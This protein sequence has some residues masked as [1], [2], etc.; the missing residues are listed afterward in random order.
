MIKRTERKRRATA[1]TLSSNITG[2]GYYTERTVRAGRMA[3]REELVREPV[4]EEEGEQYTAVHKGCARGKG[5]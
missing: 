1:V 2:V 4:G 3:K 5:R